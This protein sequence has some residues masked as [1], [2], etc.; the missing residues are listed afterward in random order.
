MLFPQDCR[1]PA[2]GIAYETWKYG[3]MQKATRYG[4]NITL[5]QQHVCRACKISVA[6]DTHAWVMNIKNP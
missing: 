1:V 4:Q 6:D 2:V 5:K 3:R